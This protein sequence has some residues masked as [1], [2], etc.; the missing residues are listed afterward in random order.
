M[1]PL[2]GSKR[3]KSWIFWYGYRVVKRQATNRIW[4][5]CK[6]CHIHKTIDA[7]GGGLFNI[8]QA[9]TSAATHLSQPK[10]GHNLRKDSLKLTLRAQG[11]LS[12]WQAFDAGL[13]MPQPTANA[14]GNFDVQ[15]F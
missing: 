5:V 10:R 12:L 15:G 2:A 8:T 14:L 7:G 4:F 13:E 11:Q 6:Y 9:T 1:K 3:P